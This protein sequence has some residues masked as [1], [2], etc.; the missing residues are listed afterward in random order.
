[1]LI[2]T[3]FRTHISVLLVCQRFFWTWAFFHTMATTLDMTA[4]TSSDK[5]WQAVTQ[6]RVTWARS[7]TALGSMPVSTWDLVCLSCKD[8]AG[9]TSP[10][11]VTCHCYN[12]SPDTTVTRHLRNTPLSHWGDHAAQGYGRDLIRHQYAEDNHCQ[13]SAFAQVYNLYANDGFILLLRFGGFYKM[14]SNEVTFGRRV[15]P[16]ITLPVIT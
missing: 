6:G 14:V 10:G 12:V 3:F 5:L 11:E 13:A 4:V 9:G 16:S 2:I 8:T 15:V 1:M 7:V